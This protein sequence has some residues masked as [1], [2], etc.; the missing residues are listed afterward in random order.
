[1]V[2]HGTDRLAA[3]GHRIVELGAPAAPIVLTGAMR[4]YELRSTD[5]LQNLTEA[6]L[7]VQLVAA[8]W[9]IDFAGKKEPDPGMVRD[10]G[11]AL[12]RDRPA[13]EQLTC[14]LEL[15]GA[16]WAGDKKQLTALLGTWGTASHGE[17]APVLNAAYMDLRKAGHYQGAML[18]YGGEWYWGL[19]RLPYLE[20]ALARELG[21]RVVHVVTPRPEAERGALALSDKP[22]TCEMWFSFRSPYVYLA[23]HQIE[24]VLA[25]FDVPL[26]LRPV[27]PM[28]R[29]GLAVPNVKR[30]YIVRDVKREADRLGIPFGNLVD[31]MGKGID[32]CIAIQHWAN[33]RGAGL[34]FAKSATRGIWS[35]ARD[36]NEPVDL[37]FLV[38]RA[39]LP[40]DEA[41]AVL[42]D[43]ASA[44]AAAENAANLNGAGLW[45]VP[46]FKVGAL[47]MWGQDRLPILVDR[48]R[49]HALATA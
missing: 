39:G 45:G 18:R 32:D 31:P 2:V 28:V 49:R 37:K 1:V 40:W 4:P 13:R 27:L 47:A 12:I 48:L 5:A 19:D 29:R 41:R 8:Y 9:N 46:S 23:L 10:I 34:A 30:M 6:L 21:T 16:L 38:E 33:Q 7:A 24:D 3:S 11:T 25:P 22:L 43:P 42:D 26:V 17:V 44:K 36:P 15:T 20:A 14:A 35:E